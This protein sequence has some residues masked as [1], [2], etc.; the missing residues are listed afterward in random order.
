[1]K[2]ID[3]WLNNVSNLFGDRKSD[4]SEIHC[5]RV[6]FSCRFSSRNF[7]RRW[8]FYL[9]KSLNGTIWQRSLTISGTV[10][11]AKTVTYL[12][13]IL[14]LLVSYLSAQEMWFSLFP[15]FKKT[16]RHMDL[17][18][19]LFKNKCQLVHSNLN[20]VFVIK[21]MLTDPVLLP[22]CF[23][24]TWSQLCRLFMKILSWYSTESISETVMILYIYIYYTIIII[25]W[26]SKISKELDLQH[27]TLIEI[28]IQSA[29]IASKQFNY[30]NLHDAW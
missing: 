2:Y 24:C 8:L 15:K 18:S 7:I 27:E 30:D 23:C 19:Y 11:S 1:M 5:Q 16:Y 13:C 3:L 29:V 6:A 28:A 26:N 4:T 25:C 21:C 10:K 22:L 9:Q 17:P 12:K 14:T 20:L